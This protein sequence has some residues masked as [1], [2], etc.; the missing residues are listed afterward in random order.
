MT[1]VKIMPLAKIFL[2]M[3]PSVI[4]YLMITKYWYFSFFASSNTFLLPYILKFHPL[5]ILIIGVSDVFK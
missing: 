3:M 4:I 2:M 5:S 1:S